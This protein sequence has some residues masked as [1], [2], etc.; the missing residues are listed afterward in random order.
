MNYDDQWAALTASAESIA[1]PPAIDRNGKS[2]SDYQRLIPLLSPADWHSEETPSREWAW[3]T[4]M[5][6]RQATYLTGP[7]SA[8]KSLLTQQLCTCIALGLPLFGLEVRQS[9]AI[10]FTAEDDEDELHRRQKAICASLGV[11]IRSLAGKLHL[12]SIVGALDASLMSQDTDDEQDSG[13]REWKPTKRFRALEG[14]AEIIDAKFIALDNVAHIFEGEENSRHDVATFVSLLNRL[15]M[16]IDGSVVF[17]GHPNKAGAEFSGSTAWE[18][19]VRSRLYLQTP[20]DENGLTADPD[21]RALSRGKAN[22]AQKGDALSFRWRQW[23]FVRDEDLPP[24]ISSE[25][26]AVARANAEN[27]G[28]L[29]CLD[30]TAAEKRAVSASPSASNYA[31]RVFAKMPSASGMRI[32]AFEGAMQRL[33]HLGQ[34]A[35]DQPVYQRDNRTWAK[36]LGRAQTLA[37]TPHK[38]C[39]QTRVEV[40]GNGAEVLHKAAHAPDPI[41]KDITGAPLGAAPVLEERPLSRVCVPAETADIVSN[42]GSNGVQKG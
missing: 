39:A 8:G 38:P 4:L 9:P 35:G 11:D 5:P 13:K 22:Y 12:V 17:L 28:F 31:P 27:E 14:V 42:G 41:S 19:Q 20:Q 30:K 16:R 36:G 18:N 24:S 25:I 40:A 7:G 3:D 10:Y 2:L 34:I 29:K 6:H 23:A 21:L 37:Q 26:A 15:A 33:L 1:R 32:S